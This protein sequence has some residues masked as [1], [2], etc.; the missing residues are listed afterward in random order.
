MYSTKVSN[1]K[2]DAKSGTK[3]YSWR[4]RQVFSYHGGDVIVKTAGVAAA[5]HGS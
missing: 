5:L 4:R 2:Y 3:C 1:S